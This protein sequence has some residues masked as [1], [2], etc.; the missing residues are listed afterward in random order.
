MAKEIGFGPRWRPKPHVR[1]RPEVHHQQTVVQ[2]ILVKGD[3]AAII[4]KPE[5]LGLLCLDACGA[6]SLR[7]Q[8]P[9]VDALKASVNKVWAAMNTNDIVNACKA[10]RSRIEA[11]IKAEGLYLRNKL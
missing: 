7:Y 1:R 2:G 3:V 10:F 6:E 5:S 8:P 9:N 4:A 11:C